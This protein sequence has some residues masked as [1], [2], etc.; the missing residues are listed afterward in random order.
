[1]NIGIWLERTAQAMPDRAAL[2]LGRDQVMDYAGFDR[3]AREAAGALLEQGVTPGDR[4]AIFMG[5]APDYLLALYG[6]WYAGAAAV[7]INAKLHGAEAAWIIENATARLTLADS[8]G[9]AALAAQGVAAQPVSRGPAVARLTARAPDDLAWLFYTSGTTGRPKGVCITHRMLIAMSLSYLADVDEVSAEDAT[10]YAAPMS[11]GAGLYAMV[12]VLRGARH[13]C[14]VSGGFEPGEILDLAQHHDRLHM[15]AAPTMVKR[16]TAHARATGAPGTGLRSVVYAGGP[17][18]LADI[19]AAVETFGP[20]FLQI[21]GQGECPMA[22]TALSRGDVADRSHPD[23]RAR[24]ASVG[25]AQSVVEV[26]IADETGAE[27]PPGKVGEILVRGDAVMPG[28]WQN[29]AASEAALR[30]GW[31]WTGDLGRMD[32][33]GY[34]TLQDR[35]KDMIISGGSNIYPREV[36]EVL[37]T[38]PSV[39]EVAVVGVPDPEWGEVVVAFVVSDGPLD[40]AALDAHCRASIARFKRPKRYIADDSLPKNNYGKVLKTDLR[41]RLDV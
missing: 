37:Q 15:F 13:V 28:Y 18:Y 34:V 22:I 26:R 40:E 3:A 14:P 21:Y 33:D 16:L 23:W 30:G 36:E 2:F 10:L 38:H 24:L 32:G 6:I 29:D 41:G 1:M 20:V 35:S 12:H 11:H 25:C 9:Q 5:N 8:T 7:P 4:I 19:I 31:L 39:I 17:M 27:R